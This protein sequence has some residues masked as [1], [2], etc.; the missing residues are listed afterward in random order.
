[1]KFLFNNAIHMIY[2]ILYEHIIQISFI[3]Y[4][5][6]KKCIHMQLVIFP[7]NAHERSTASVPPLPLLYNK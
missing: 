4:F 6:Y 2:E 5:T 1:M 3:W 7:S